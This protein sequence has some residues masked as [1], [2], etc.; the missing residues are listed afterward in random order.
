MST[1]HLA[2]PGR[3]LASRVT[4][5]RRASSPGA[6]GGVLFAVVLA[7][8]ITACA[9]TAPDRVAYSSIDTAVDAVQAALTVFNVAYQDGVKTDPVTW[10]ARRAEAKD[11][12]EKFQVTARS[13]TKLAAA[14]LDPEH[15]ASAIQLVSD[16]AFEALKILEAFKG[17][18]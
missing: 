9:G 6:L 5:P 3:R 16:A 4:S 11:A 7:V 14:A 12:Y 18:K 2:V 13:G 15:K 1:N 17:G 8:A 10:N